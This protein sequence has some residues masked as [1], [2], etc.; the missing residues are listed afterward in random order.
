M[1]ARIKKDGDV[2]ITDTGLYIKR[3]KY[4]EQKAKVQIAMWILLAPFLVF[5]AYMILGIGASMPFV[6]GGTAVLL[7]LATFCG[8]DLVK[9][10]VARQDAKVGIDDNSEKNLLFQLPKGKTAYK[11]AFENGVLTWYPFLN[12]S[13]HLEI[14][15]ADILQLDFGWGIIE[16]WLRDKGMTWKENDVFPSAANGAV[17]GIVLPFTREIEGGW[18]NV[19][20]KNEP[21][22]SHWIDAPENWIKSSSAEICEG[23][24]LLITK[25]FDVSFKDLKTIGITFSEKFN[26]P[27]R[28]EGKEIDWK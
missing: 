15:Q 3:E 20:L 7:L 23:R 18:I 9:R 4:I 25:G 26:L 24:Q 27:V 11:L 10:W 22:K 14:N 2:E 12:R 16:S 5:Y 8:L 28:Y 19:Q 6:I 13:T 17:G 1:R 21:L